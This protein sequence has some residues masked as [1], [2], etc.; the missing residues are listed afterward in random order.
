MEGSIARSVEGS[1]WGGLAGGL[2][3]RLRQGR[4]QGEYEGGIVGDGRRGVGSGEGE[5]R[6]DGGQA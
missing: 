5:H 3:D 1:S 6:E 2:E 4:G